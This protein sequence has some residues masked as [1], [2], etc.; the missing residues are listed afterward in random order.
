VHPGASAEA[1]RVH[2][3][4][5]GPSAGGGRGTRRGLKAGK[6]RGPLHGIPI[7]YKDN[8]DTAGI[9]TTNGLPVLQQ[10]CGDG[11]TLRSCVC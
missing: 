5:R 7:V 6:D 8:C 9:L 2:H 4:A 11:G 3:G 10:A 1:K